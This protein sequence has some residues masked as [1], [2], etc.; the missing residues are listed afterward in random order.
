MKRVTRL[1]FAQLLFIR[2]M[3]VVIGLQVAFVPQGHGRVAQT[4]EDGMSQILGAPS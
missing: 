3:A 2:S 4:F 1:A